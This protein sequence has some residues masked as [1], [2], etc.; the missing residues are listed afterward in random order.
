MCVL[1]K[2]LDATGQSG[3]HAPRAEQ[4]GTQH[5]I[6]YVLCVCQEGEEPGG[7]LKDEV[8]PHLQHV[9]MLQ[10]LRTQGSPEQARVVVFI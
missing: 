1:E 8:M 7:G 3:L 2:C 6:L 4:P 10:I 5:G 9:V